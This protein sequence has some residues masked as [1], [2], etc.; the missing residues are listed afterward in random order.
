MRKLFDKIF[1]PAQ[2]VGTIESLDPMKAGDWSEWGTPIE[3]N[4]EHVIILPPGL[5]YT[6][7][8]PP[9]TSIQAVAD[10]VS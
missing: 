9:Q 10:M 4:V 5:K 8:R 6:P 1:R 7:A 2:P 3:L